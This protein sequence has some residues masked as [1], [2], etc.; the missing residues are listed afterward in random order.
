VTEAATLLS[1]A[2]RDAGFRRDALYALAGTAVIAASAQVAVPMVP[3]PMTMQSLVILIV[4][5]AY[6]WRLGGAT[7]ALYLAE[8]LVGLPVFANFH[9]G[10]AALFGPTGGYLFGFVAAAALAGW[11][12][13]R[14]W[15]RDVFRTGLAMLAGHILLFAAGLSWLANFIGWEKAVALGFVP[16][17]LGSIVKIALGATLMPALWGVVAK[18]S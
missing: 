10:P 4:G 5:M 2:R 13:E 16:F 9:A 14:G 7:V 1:A 12:A 11:L 17:I 15:S 3:V 6:G 8:G 18:R